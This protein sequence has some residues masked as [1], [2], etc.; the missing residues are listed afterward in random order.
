MSFLESVAGDVFPV[1]HELRGKH[2]LSIKVCDVIKYC[3]SM[4][5]ESGPILLALSCGKAVAVLLGKG[6]L[7]LDDLK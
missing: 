7:G 2:R 3:T 6:C 1:H 5:A 4:T